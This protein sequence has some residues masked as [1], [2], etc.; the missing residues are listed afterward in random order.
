MSQFS[1]V[2]LLM[3]GLLTLSIFFTISHITSR[4]CSCIGASICGQ[5]QYSFPISQIGPRNPFTGSVS[6][7]VI[8][9]CQCCKTTLTHT[10]A[11][12]NDDIC[13]FLCLDI[14]Y[15]LSDLSPKGLDTTMSDL[16]SVFILS[17][18]RHETNC[19]WG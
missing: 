13:L 3:R 12:R 15:M 11:K 9:N 1:S 5:I 19:I 18:L 10:R 16:F 8:K 7:T 2:F 6:E 14:Y 17:L 4:D